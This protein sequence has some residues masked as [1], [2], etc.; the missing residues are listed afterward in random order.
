MLCLNKD[1]DYIEKWPLKVISYINYTYLFGY[2]TFG[3]HLL[4]VLFP[5]QS[6]K[7]TS[8]KEIPVYQ[9]TLVAQSDACATGDRM[10]DPGW[11]QLHSSVDL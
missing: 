4:I 2:D 7:E 11:V 8:Y 6:Y 3:V 5:K 1:V 10:F 9:Q